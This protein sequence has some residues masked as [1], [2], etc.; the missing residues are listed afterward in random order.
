[1]F[2][3]NY[4]SILIILVISLIISSLI[5]ILSSVFFFQTFNDEKNAIYE[6]GFSPFSDA[7]NNFDVKFYLISILYIVFDLEI[8]F[9][10][11]CVLSFSKLGF[12]G[13]GLLLTILLIIWVGFYYEWTKGAMDF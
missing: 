1:M 7:R 3:I 9:L 10:L 11:P 2:L 4:S 13:I 12:L 5:F 8:I 6:C